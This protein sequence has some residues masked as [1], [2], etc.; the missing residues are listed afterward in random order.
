VKADRML[1]ILL[2]LQSEGKLSASEL[3]RR[4]EVS[5]RTIMRDMESLSMSGVP[6]YAERGSRG[7][8]ALREGYQTNL[9][10]MKAE[11][12][13]SLM[14]AA[15]PSLLRDL[16]IKEHYDA[17]YRKLIASSP[18]TIRHSAELMW[19]K[20]HIDGTSWHPADDAHSW[21]STI[22]E[23]VWMQRQLCIHYKRDQ[24]IHIRN[25][26][27]LG[28]V[29]KRSIWYL[30]AEVGDDYRNYRISRVVY[31]Q[32]LPSGFSMPEHFDLERY[33][34]HSTRQFKI[35]LPRYPAKLRVSESAATRLLHERYV[36]I[37]Q[38][39]KSSETDRLEIDIE[40]ATLEHAA[41]S[42]LSYGA[43]I[44]VL[45]PAEL[46]DQVIHQAKSI[47]ELYGAEIS[48]EEHTSL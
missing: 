21:L 33:W 16:G 43:A 34:E 31:A 17:A 39:T 37:V 18:E 5:E 29:A 7:G 24:E 32:V 14:I 47:M 13:I 15:N 48:R 26:N 30:V 44:E 3:A 4:L 36:T 19:K 45:E 28:I 41:E 35:N 10:G 42:V 8:W 9:T 25:V 6:I 20:V 22:Q 1:S 38:Q 46:R 12:F 40:F 2:L 11:E 27:P 23:A